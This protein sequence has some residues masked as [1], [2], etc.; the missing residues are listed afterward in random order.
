MP[1]RL[2]APLWRTP[3]PG[4]G[5]DEQNQ[6]HVAAHQQAISRHREQWTRAKTPPAFWEIGFPSTPEV[7]EINAQAAAMHDEKREMVRAEAR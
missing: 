6:N 7:K 2:Q 1:S 4:A 3:S 5:A